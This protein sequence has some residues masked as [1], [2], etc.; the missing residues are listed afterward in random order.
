[1]ACHHDDIHELLFVPFTQLKM[2]IRVTWE[3][4]VA[5]HATMKLIIKLVLV[6]LKLR[7]HS[8]CSMEGMQTLVFLGKLWDKEL[9]N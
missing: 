2:Y 4:L 5:N 7:C 3:A 1:M 6:S 8:P 9:Q